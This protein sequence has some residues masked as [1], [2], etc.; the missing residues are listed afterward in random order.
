MCLLEIGATDFSR[1]NVS[2]DSQNWN[3]ASIRIVESIDKVQ[4]AWAT[5]TC[6]YTDLAGQRR[7]CSGSERRRLLVPHPN[8]LDPMLLAYR[9]G[10]AVQ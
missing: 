5:T 10:D 6:A 3:P 1:R 9:I 8:P 2:G 7:L 4:I